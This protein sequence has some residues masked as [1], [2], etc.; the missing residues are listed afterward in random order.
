MCSKFVYSGLVNDWLKIS[1]KKYF[2]NIYL[3]IYLKENALTYKNIYIFVLKYFFIYYQ[4]KLIFEHF[5]F[6]ECRA[7]LYM[8]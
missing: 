3:C 2:F 1:L 8:L 6:K 5:Y 7:S 4:S